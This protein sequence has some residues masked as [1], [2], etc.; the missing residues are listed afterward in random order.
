VIGEMKT[1]FLLLRILT[2]LSVS[3]A[4]VVL[5]AIILLRSGAVFLKE[6]VGVAGYVAQLFTSGFTRG[7][8][9]PPPRGWVV[10]LPQGGLAVLFGAMI[11][12]L[13]HPDAKILLHIIAI[14]A[15]VAVIWYVRMLVMDDVKLEIL[16]LP[17]LAVWFFYYAMCIFWSSN[18][19]IAAIT[20]S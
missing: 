15:G 3:T 2:G 11:V 6:S 20:R 4:L 8:A 18:Q 5:L 19:P 7:T 17:L 12:S 14:M 13:F 1:L 16:C 9:P 10:G